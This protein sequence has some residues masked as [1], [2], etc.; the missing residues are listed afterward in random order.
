MTPLADPETVAAVDDR[1]PGA[2]IEREETMSQVLR[3]MNSLPKN[4]REVLRLKFQGDLSYK[5][6]SEI[7]RLSVTNVGFLI[8]TALRAIRKQVLSEPARRT[9]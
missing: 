1:R 8:H 6:I 9:Q 7:T 3:L 2:S 5:E 4:Q